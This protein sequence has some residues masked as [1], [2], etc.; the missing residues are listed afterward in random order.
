[1]YIYMFIYVYTHMIHIYIYIF[2]I[3]LY[4]HVLYVYRSLYMCIY[5]YVYVYTH[6]YIYIYVNYTMYLDMFCCFRVVVH[7]IMQDSYHQHYDEHAAVWD[8][9]LSLHSCLTSCAS[10][11]TFSFCCVGE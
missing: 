3:C 8:E 11:W 4:V 7:E 5:V 2:V 6:V 10:T 9:G 1:M